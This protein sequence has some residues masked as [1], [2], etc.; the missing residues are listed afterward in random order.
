MN[1]RLLSL[2][3]SVPTIRNGHETNTSRY[4]YCTCKS[5]FILFHSKKLIQTF[6]SG[7]CCHNQYCKSVTAS[8]QRR[9]TSLSETP[10]NALSDFI[11]QHV[12]KTV[13]SYFPP[14]PSVGGNKIL[15]LTKVS[16]IKSDFTASFALAK[17]LILLHVLH[18]N[19]LRFGNKS[20]KSG[21]NIDLFKSSSVNLTSND[22][23]SIRAWRSPSKLSYS[24]T[25]L[26]SYRGI[27]VTR[28]LY[29][30]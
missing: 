21:I 6:D 17:F 16:L 14:T 2:H 22:N 1:S 10:G 11:S 8:V 12:R 26:G 27:I 7:N 23:I 19:Y 25:S 28:E 20:Q 18:M 30:R 5:Y 13:I 29:R 15:Y 9:R 24:W 3:F 4:M